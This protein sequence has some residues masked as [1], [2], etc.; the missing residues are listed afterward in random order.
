MM[1]SKSSQRLCAIL[2]VF[3]MLAFIML[4]VLTISLFNSIRVNSQADEISTT[5]ID[6]YIQNQIREKQLPGLAISIVSG[7]EI[8]YQHGFGFSSLNTKLPV[9]PQTIF[10]LASCSKSFTALSVLILWKDGLIDL[11]KPLVYYLS[12]F[13]LTDSESSSKITIRQLLNQTSGLP[14]DVSEP[15]SY[16]QGSDAM[17]KLV[18]A[19]GGIRLDNPPGT[20]FEY[21]NFNYN[22]LGALVEKVSG[23]CFEDFVQERILTPMNMTDSTLRP[24]V[25]LQKDRADGHQLLLGKVVVRN[26]PIYRSAI[27]AGWVMS[28]VEDMSKWLIMNLNHGAIDG[29][30]VFPAELVDMT[31]TTAITLFE[32]GKEA[33]YGMG[34]FIG[35]AKSGEPVYWH[36]GDTPNFLSEMIL[37]PEKQLGIVMLI[38]GQTCKN[39]HEI[40]TG[41]LSLVL[42]VR[43]ELPQAPW[44]ASWKSVD[45][46]SIYATI[47]SIVLILGLVPF[48]PWQVQVI[49]R[50]RQNTN[51]QSTN[52]KKMKIWRLIPPVTPWMILILIASV[53][54]VVMQ[55]LFG[56]NIFV[57]IWRFGY[58]APPGTLVAAITILITLFLWAI[59]LSITAI[60]RE[61]S[62]VP[63]S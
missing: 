50:L 5:E 28:S 54:Y 7:Q 53:A 26:V 13:H 23:K 55:S 6:R 27:P 15:V 51:T 29:K 38:N 30:Q 63:R 48:I 47:L 32:D 36:G 61:L 46:I 14:G 8:I 4:A 24:E 49:K 62:R 58:F 35:T 18:I 9:T 25:A 3:R 39:A 34:W 2:T 1:L 52:K 57:T 10:D 37:L 45:N 40:A 19:M 60:F 12:E 59:A 21:A 56:F 17:N 20:R 16:H 31:H 42:S 11:D 44:W 43:F 33:G 22:L 41:V